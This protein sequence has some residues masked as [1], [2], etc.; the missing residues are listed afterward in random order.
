MPFHY[1]NVDEYERWPGTKK[2]TVWNRHCLAKRN[3]CQPNQLRPAFWKALRGNRIDHGSWPVNSTKAW[4]QYSIHWD[5]CQVAA[6]LRTRDSRMRGSTGLHS[7][8]LCLSPLFNVVNGWSGRC[9]FD[10]KIIRRYHKHWSL[11]IPSLR[12]SPWR[13]SWTHPRWSW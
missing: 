5:F 12:K 1:P 2:Q 4:C 3:F 13:R 10:Q 11:L 7:N 6:T 9:F 8:F